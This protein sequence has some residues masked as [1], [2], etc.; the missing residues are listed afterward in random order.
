MLNLFLT[1]LVTYGL[2]SN[3]VVNSGVGVL[4][5]GREKRYKLFRYIST[6]FLMLGIAQF[7]HIF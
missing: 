5:F 4:L 3:I 1:D 2:S 7:H 6:L